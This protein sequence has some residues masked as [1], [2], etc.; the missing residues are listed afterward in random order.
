MGCLRNTASLG[1]NGPAGYGTY[2][3]ESDGA[4]VTGPPR[5]VEYEEPLEEAAILAA[6]MATMLGDPERPP[7]GGPEGRSL[8]GE[9]SDGGRYGALMLW[10]VG[11]PRYRGC[12]APEPPGGGW[13][14]EEVSWICRTST[15]R[16]E[17]DI[18]V[19]ESVQESSCCS[20]ISPG[21]PQQHG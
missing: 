11:G 13:D 19:S 8:L 20:T 5:N 7:I 6:D 4:A 15:G 12:G 3:N 18:V 17:D 2:L 21:Q 10:V 14:P 16:A 9:E 1:L